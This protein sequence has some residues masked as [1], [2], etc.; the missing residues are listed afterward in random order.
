MEEILKEIKKL[1]K[2]NQNEEAIKYIDKVLKKKKK[3]SD[4]IDELVNDLK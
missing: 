4:Y 3:P 2:N 1:I